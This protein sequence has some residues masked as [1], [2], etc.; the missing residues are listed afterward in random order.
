ME[1]FHST[2]ITKVGNSLAITIP[3]EILAACMWER[4]DRVVFGVLDGPTLVVKQI[5]EQDIRR[6][7]PTRDINF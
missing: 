6:L 3:K 1:T 7:K 2:K 5:S 4:G